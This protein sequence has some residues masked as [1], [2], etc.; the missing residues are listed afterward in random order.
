MHG[1]PELQAVL[2]SGSL[3]RM[4]GEAGRVTAEPRGEVEGQRHG[5]Q[6]G[7]TR[8]EPTGGLGLQPAGPG[9]DGHVTLTCRSCRCFR[10]TPAT[11]AAVSSTE[12]PSTTFELLD[13]PAQAAA[14]SSFRQPRAPG[15]QPSARR[16][17]FGPGLTPRA[18]SF[19]VLPASRRKQS[20]A[21]H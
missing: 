21:E 15:P 3:P 1:H 10:C 7:T 5:E 6:P 4:R 14:A 2:A 16:C 19:R 17:R 12:R 13:I 8:T 11:V 18:Q 9:R 20:R